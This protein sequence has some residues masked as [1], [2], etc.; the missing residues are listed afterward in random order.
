M[1]YAAYMSKYAEQSGIA[2]GEREMWR[3]EEITALKS[4]YINEPL[5]QR[6]KSRMKQ[7][8]AK[9][10]EIILHGCFS[11]S[12]MHKNSTMIESA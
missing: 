8:G 6:K 5:H 2:G 10:M 4:V 7:N 3:A 1:A 9:Y 12:S 11:V